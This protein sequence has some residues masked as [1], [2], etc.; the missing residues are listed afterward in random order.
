MSKDAVV[1]IGES[2]AFR[3]A[4][5]RLQRIAK[6]DATVL[7]EG[8]T[9]T[10]KELA[11]RVV[12][13]EGARS[14]G[15]FIPINCGAIP[16]ALLESELF[17]FKQGAFTDAK[18]SAPGVLLLAHGGTLFLD[19]VDSLSLKAQVALLR[20][21]Q[22][23]SIRPL[24]SG[25]ERKVDVR[26]VAATNRNLKEL[27][28]QRVFRHDLYYRL[29]V[30]NV[31]LPP[32]RERDA[33]V[34]M[35]ASHLL[36]QFAARYGT[37]VQKFDEP[38]IQWLRSH[39]WPGNVRELENLIE[40][41]LLLA[42]CDTPLRLSFL[43]PCRTRASTGDADADADADAK[44]LSPLDDQPCGWNYRRAKARLLEE[45]DR[46]FLDRLMRFARGNVALAA[47][48]AGKERRELGRLLR[49]YDLIPEA[50]RIDN[51]R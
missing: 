29:N 16:D 42:D 31:E 25:A 37:Q 23:R 44:M 3:A 21:L 32:L 4:R 30:M 24:G 49:K 34:E 18:T 17:G 19:E 20:F 22:D 47:R 10:G 6:T 2:T 9:G 46:S 27:V 45:F 43:Y 50:F 35:F 26:I 1:F 5:E 11:A 40:R 39:S 13:Y 36:R 48:T 12:H 8:E 33:D 7:I 51:R 41:E 15:P 14:G 38:S 28:E